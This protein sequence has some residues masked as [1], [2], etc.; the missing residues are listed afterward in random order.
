MIQKSSKI[1]TSSK[2]LLIIFIGVMVCGGFVTTL[3]V[4][5]LT[6]QLSRDNG[7][8]GGNG[9]IQGQFSIHATS[10]SNMKIAQWFVY[11]NQ[12]EVYNATGESLSWGFSTDTYELGAYNITV[13]G[14]DS[15]GEVYQGSKSV[16]FVEE[17]IWPYFILVGAAII[18]V[19]S[20]SA[21]YK[22]YRKKKQNPEG[23]KPKK[24]DISINLDKG[25]L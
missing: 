17:P 4:N 8:S 14:I 12:L 22:Q 25:L 18:V 20:L 11:F 7:Y 21:K 9:D 23:D 1:G 2:H 10:T 6:F 15:Q 19:I 13:V 16:V 3:S 24:E 5:S